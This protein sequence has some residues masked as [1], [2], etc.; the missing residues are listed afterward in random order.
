[1]WYTDS[2][3]DQFCCPKLEFIQDILKMCQKYM[4]PSKYHIET[5]WQAGRQLFQKNPN[6]KLIGYIY[7][8][9]M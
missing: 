6:V 2:T 7:S 5:E 8:I 9:N 3:Q 4:N 1:M